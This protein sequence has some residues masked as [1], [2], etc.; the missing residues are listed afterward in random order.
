MDV[1]FI[2]AVLLAAIVYGVYSVSKLCRFRVRPWVWWFVPVL[3]L[4]FDGLSVLT[5]VVL[6]LDSTVVFIALIGVLF[7]LLTMCAMIAVA[8][9][10]WT[11]GDPGA[12][13]KKQFGGLASFWGQL[14]VTLSVLGVGAIYRLKDGYDGNPPVEKLL[15]F[16]KGTLQA[17]A[18]WHVLGRWPF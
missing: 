6:K 3:L 11:E 12:V 17:H 4:V 15:C 7:A 13:V 10:N 2:Y 8:L 18:L 9:G 5:K 16:P 1:V 14:V